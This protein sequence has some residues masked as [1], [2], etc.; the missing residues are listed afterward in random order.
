MV[1]DWKFHNYIHFDTGTIPLS[2]NGIAMVSLG[3]SILRGC[4]SRLQP[5]GASMAHSFSVTVEMSLSVNT[6]RAA[7]VDRQFVE[8]G[9]LIFG[10]GDANKRTS[11]ALKVN[12]L[13]FEMIKAPPEPYR[14]DLIVNPQ[15]DSCPK[16]TEV[17]ALIR[18]HQPA[19]ARFRFKL[20][21]ELSEL[22]EIKARKLG[23]QHGGPACR[24]KGSI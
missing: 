23:G 11:F 9:E 16:K 17:T 1:R 14:V 5:D 22:I 18:Y 20:D 8:G 7:S 2:T 4:D 15:G 12:C 19:T 13:A 3:D 6:R 10:G 21:G 24:A